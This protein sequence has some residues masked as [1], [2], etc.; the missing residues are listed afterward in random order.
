MPKSHRRYLQ[1]TPSRLLRWAS[2]NGPYT[3]KLAAA[4]WTPVPIPSKASVHASVS[5]A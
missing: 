5:C 4:I 2:K 1:W 3:E